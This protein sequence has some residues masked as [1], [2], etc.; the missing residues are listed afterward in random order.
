[1]K[2]RAPKFFPGVFSKVVPAGWMILHLL[3]TY[4]VN[5][6][7][8]LLLRVDWIWPLGR[9]LRRTGQKGCHTQFLIDLTVNVT[10]N[11]FS[12]Q[13]LVL[14]RGTCTD[15][16]SAWYSHEQKS[17]FRKEVYCTLVGV[18]EHCSRLLKT[19][20]DEI[21]LRIMETLFKAEIWLMNK[22]LPQL[23]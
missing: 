13:C 5:P 17:L 2:A 14:Q 19:D 21:S 6:I 3:N 1:M 9:P 20:V 15:T 10:R 12:K 7:V 22:T 16:A 11:H 23:L 18:L 4:P 8:I